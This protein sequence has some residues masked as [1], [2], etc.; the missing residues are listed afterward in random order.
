VKTQKDVS[1]L[2]ICHNTMDQVPIIFVK[3]NIKNPVSLSPILMYN[4]K[5][6]FS[7]L[8][9]SLSLCVSVS[10]C[11]CVYV[12]LSLSVSVSGSLCLCLS[13]TQTKNISHTLSLIS[14]MVRHCLANDKKTF[15]TYF[16]LH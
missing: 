11:L 10:M 6:F 14:F 16:C 8:S 13:H 15:E 4:S 1:P 2:G 5:L 7:F 9:V 12:S 3:A